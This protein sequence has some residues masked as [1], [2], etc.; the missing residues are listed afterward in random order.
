VIPGQL[1]LHPATSQL[2]DLVRVD[3]GISENTR[4]HEQA[5]LN[6]VFN[7]LIRQAHWKCKSPLE[8]LRRLKFD[9]PELAFLAQE[10]IESLLEES[11][12]SF[13]PSVY[14]AARLAL[15]TGTTWSKAESAKPSEFTPYRDTYS[16]TKSGKS[17][18]VPLRK[19]LY[20]ESV[21]K[22]PFRSCC[23]AFRSALQRADI[24]LPKGQLTHICRRIFANHF[25]MN[26]GHTLAYS[27]PS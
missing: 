10:E 7:G 3:S 23:S 13:N 9:E 17:R 27:A 21:E 14:H 2:I 26:G 19:D 20:E 12:V 18:S 25:V 6:A 4:N 15:A 22:L 1:D 5:Y 24:K 11:R 16:G 8:K